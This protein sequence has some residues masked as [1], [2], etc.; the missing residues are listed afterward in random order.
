METIRKLALV[1]GATKVKNTGYAIARRFARK[2]YDVCLTSRSLEEALHAANCLKQEV[3]SCR[4][5]GLR[6][7]PS[8]PEDIEAMYREIEEKYKRLDVLVANA[9]HLGVGLDCL[10]TTPAQFD[11]VMSCNARGYFFCAQGAAKLMIQCGARG[12]I[13]FISSVH[14]RGAIGNRA[15][16]AASKGAVDA[17]CRSFALELGQ[18]GIRANSI[19]AGAIYSDRWDGLSS[20]AM[21]ARRARYPVGRESKP[22][23]IAA[24]CSYLASDEAYT[25]TGT[26]LVVDS[27]VSICVNGYDP[28]WEDKK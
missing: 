4:A 1:T 18:Y 12:S 26:D 7:D 10:H 3:P 2:G 19:I 23:E 13:I 25:V 17:M 27:G 16:Y 22:E 6:L 5:C 21:A 15:V 28:R 24:A 9:A 8:R 11:E 14:A 20:E